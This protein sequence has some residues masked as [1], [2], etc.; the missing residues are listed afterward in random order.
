[1]VTLLAEFYT[2]IKLIRVKIFSLY[3]LL[4]SNIA[5]A[6]TQSI[7]LNKINDQGKKQGYWKMFLDE[8]FTY[9]DSSNAKYSAF[10]YYNDGKIIIGKIPNWIKRC[11]IK[12]APELTRV[13][14]ISVLNGIY[15]FID[16][17]KKNGWSYILE[18]KNGVLIRDKLNWDGSG[19]HYEE[20]FYSKKFNDIEGSYYVVGQIKPDLIEKGYYY[21]DNGKLV[22]NL[23]KVKN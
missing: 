8:K 6:Q 17:G 10:V 12:S 22:N 19:Y 23:E 21:L 2:G 1:M 18:Y 4:V 5:I 11:Q 15:E 3:F 16:N 13:S 14:E 7:E 20:C 9:T